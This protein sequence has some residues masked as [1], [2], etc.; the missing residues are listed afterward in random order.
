M[1]FYIIFINIKHI[2]IDFIVKIINIKSNI[3]YFIIN[4]NIK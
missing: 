2:Y 3:I 4:N 1:L